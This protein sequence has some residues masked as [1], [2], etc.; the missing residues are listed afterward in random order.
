M[1]AVSRKWRRR[2][3]SHIF[4]KL[5]KD[6]LQTKMGRNYCYLEY[7]SPSVYQCKPD[8]SWASNNRWFWYQSQSRVKWV[9][10]TN[11]TCVN[12]DIRQSYF[13]V[14]INENIKYFY[15]QSHC[16]LLS[17]NVTNY[18]LIVCLVS[19]SKPLITVN[20]LLAF[21]CFPFVSDLLLS[22]V[23]KAI[24]RICSTWFNLFYS[25]PNQLCTVGFSWIRIIS[26]QSEVVGILS[27]GF[28]SLDVV[29][30]TY[31]PIG[32]FQIV[33]DFDENWV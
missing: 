1:G 23:N 19:G 17:N 3:T 28:L 27:V 7:C 6:M 4:R 12:P 21:I 31:N 11:V 2:T 5:T 16:W 24:F 22:N 30:T 29:E 14:N 20:E 18:Q 10:T 26:V 33:L 25:L 15:K 13:K 32:T 8:D 9:E